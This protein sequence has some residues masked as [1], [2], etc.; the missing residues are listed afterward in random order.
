MLQ[1]L[2]LNVS[3]GVER[4]KLKL[5]NASP[6]M[7]G[8]EENFDRVYIREQGR[9]PRVHE[10]KDRLSEAGGMFWHWNANGIFTIK[11]ILV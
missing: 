4:K 8:D 9:N 3:D 2:F 11:S 10:L 1:F 5:V 6:V 7:G